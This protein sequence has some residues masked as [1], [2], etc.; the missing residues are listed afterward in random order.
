MRMNI[1]MLLIVGGVIGWIASMIMRTDAKQGIILK[2]IVGIVGSALGGLLL[3][4]LLGIP[5]LTQGGG[6][7]LASLGVS[8]AGTV[9][10]LA[11]WNLHQ[12]GQIR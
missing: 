7:N 12:R 1:L 9:I 8:L 2:I 6:L 11:A 10:L 3:A 5:S 4:P